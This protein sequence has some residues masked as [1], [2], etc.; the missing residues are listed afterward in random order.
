MES[1]RKKTIL[2]SF[3]S[4]VAFLIPMGGML[5]LIKDAPC[6]PLVAL[7]G[8]LSHMNNLVSFLLVLGLILFLLGA[9]VG[10]IGYRAFVSEK[11]VLKIGAILLILMSCLGAGFLILPVCD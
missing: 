6:A 11:R 9:L 7:E 2:I 1:S 8:P 3:W 10:W 5:L 4:G